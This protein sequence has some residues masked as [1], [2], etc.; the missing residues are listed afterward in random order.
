MVVHLVT[1]PSEI[2]FNITNG[3]LE[4]ENLGG[5]KYI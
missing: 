1:W 4:P 5:D 3:L 2:K